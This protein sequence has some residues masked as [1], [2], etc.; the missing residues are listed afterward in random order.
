[1][2]LFDAGY[3]YGAIIEITKRQTAA[4][5]RNQWLLVIAPESIKF[6][7]VVI[8]ASDEIAFSMRGSLSNVVVTASTECTVKL[9][10]M[11]P[12]TAAF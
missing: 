7:V 10:H 4:H 3:N 11:V 2:I 12:R 8:F 9:A 5:A 1:M 6:F